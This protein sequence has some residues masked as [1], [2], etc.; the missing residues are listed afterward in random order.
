MC[1]FIVSKFKLAKT[2]NLHVVRK[3]VLMASVSTKSSPICSIETTVTFCH[4]IIVN[5]LLRKFIFNLIEI[6]YFKIYN[7]FIFGMRPSFT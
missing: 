1:I 4:R 6:A 2:W 5:V 7:C 3:A